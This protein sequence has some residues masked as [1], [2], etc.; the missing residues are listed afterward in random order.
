MVFSPNSK[1][2]TLIDRSPYG[3]L[4]LARF[5][6]KDLLAQNWGEKNT[7]GVAERLKAA[8]C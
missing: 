3:Q 8:V 7:G 2:K 1:K 5:R 6:D 4:N